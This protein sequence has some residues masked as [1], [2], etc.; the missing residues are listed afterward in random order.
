MTID[1]P[2]AKK[3]LI[4][5]NRWLNIEYAKGGPKLLSDGIARYMMKKMR[6]DTSLSPKEAFL[7]INKNIS[8]RILL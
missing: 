5:G 3:N 4:E 6:A 8:R 7:A 1:G 2:S